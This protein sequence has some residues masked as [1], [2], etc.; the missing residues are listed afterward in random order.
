MSHGG[1]ERQG[2]MDPDLSPC[3][4]HRLRSPVQGTERCG[5]AS[6]LSVCEGVLPTGVVLDGAHC[7]RCSQA[8]PPPG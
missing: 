7:H 3:L 8:G 4:T 5:G 1:E 2:D 6:T